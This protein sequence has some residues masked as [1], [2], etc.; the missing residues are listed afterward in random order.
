MQH[1]RTATNSYCFVFSYFMLD[2]SKKKNNY[3][4]FV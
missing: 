2:Y 3:I 4:V 1:I